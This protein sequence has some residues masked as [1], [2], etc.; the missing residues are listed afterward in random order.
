MD[1]HHV[2]YLGFY[3]VCVGGGGVQI[4]FRKVRVFRHAF[5]NGVRGHALPKKN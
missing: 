2:A 4:N 3:L 1:P 5:A